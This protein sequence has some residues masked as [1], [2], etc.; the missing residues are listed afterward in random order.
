MLVSSSRADENQLSCVKLKLE[1]YQPSQ[2][3]QKL[4]FLKWAYWEDYAQC[5]AQLSSWTRRTPCSGLLVAQQFGSLAFIN[6]MVHWCARRATWWSGSLAICV[7]QI[8][9]GVSATQLFRLA[10]LWFG[11]LAV[12]HFGQCSVF[13]NLA[14]RAFGGSA[15]RRFGDS[16]VRR[17]GDS[18]V[19][20]FIDCLANALFSGLVFRLGNSFV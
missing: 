16:A 20:R 13:S 3:I 6:S 7:R 19:Q 5:H 2:Q 12:Q 4:A 1:K 9:S 15:V 17:F 10:V 8:G 14:A 18:T 11:R